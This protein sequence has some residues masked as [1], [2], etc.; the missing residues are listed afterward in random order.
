MP[1][2]PGSALIAFFRV[3]LLVEALDVHLVL[4]MRFIANE[5]TNVRF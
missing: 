2:M 5:N 3:I 4:S 1:Y